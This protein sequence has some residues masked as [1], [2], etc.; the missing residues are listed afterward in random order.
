MAQTLPR[1]QVTMAIHHDKLAV[2]EVHHGIL[3]VS[4]VLCRK[5]ITKETKVTHHKIMMDACM[6][7]DV[8][9]PGD[10]VLGHVLNCWKCV[11]LCMG[12]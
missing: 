8:D 10:N 6:D 3:S 4:P 9:Q 2:Y 5:P 7:N 11:S 1:T 12:L